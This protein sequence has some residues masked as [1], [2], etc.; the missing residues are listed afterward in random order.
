MEN[1]VNSGGGGVE[2]FFSF[3]GGLTLPLSG[4]LGQGRNQTSSQGWA[5]KWRFLPGLRAKRAGVQR[6]EPP[7][8][9][10]GAEPPGGGPGAEPPAGVQGGGATG[11]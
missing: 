8:G 10:Q 4:C 1:Y 2:P 7:A 6:A 11:S 9:V 5:R 3:P